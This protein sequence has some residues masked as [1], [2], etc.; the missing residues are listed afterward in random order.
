VS[1]TS[2]QAYARCGYRFYLQRVLGL[3]DDPAPLPPEPQPP[4]AGGLDGRLRGTLAHRLLEA[5]D[6]ARPAAP[7]PEAVLALAA[8]HGVALDPAQVEDLRGLVAAVAASPLCARI[9]AARR[10]RREAPFAFTADPGGTGPLVT[11]YLDVLAEAPDG[12]VLIVDYKSDRLEGRAPEEVLERDYATQRIVYA[13]AAL[14][15]GAPRAEVAYIFLERPGEPVVSRFTAADAGALGERL[16]GLA[17]GVL[18]E[19]WTVTDRP[20]RELCGD[21]PGRRAL[22]SWPEAVTLELSRP[23]DLSAA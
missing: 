4:A 22:C 20:H 2:L 10:V 17:R 14:R 19:R 11:G 13:L 23:A 16:L 6:F 8:E 21:C 15:H 5:L 18:D 7:P 1:Y 3:A 9:A 12:A